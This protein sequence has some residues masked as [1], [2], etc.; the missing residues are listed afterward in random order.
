MSKGTYIEAARLAKV[1]AYVEKIAKLREECLAETGVDL[2]VNDTVNN[3]RIA[4]VVTKYDEHFEANFGRNGE[5][6]RSKDIDDIEL[7]CNTVGKYKRTGE[8]KLSSYAFHAMGKLDHPAYMFVGRDAETANPFLIFD[9]RNKDNAAKVAAELHRMSDE[10]YETKAKVKKTSYDV[11]Q[12]TEK[13]IH[14]NL[15][16]TSI[17]DIDGVKVYRDL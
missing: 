13:F 2:T 5:D 1:T 16:F 14:D 17:E 12:L 7:K 8:Y 9:I 4:N 3:T 10:W 11:I 15:T 6:A